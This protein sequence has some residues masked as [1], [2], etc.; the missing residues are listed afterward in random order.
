M[1][2]LFCQ[3]SGIFL[4]MFVRKKPNTSGIISVQIMNKSLGKYELFKP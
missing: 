4:E 1:I 2:F 3:V